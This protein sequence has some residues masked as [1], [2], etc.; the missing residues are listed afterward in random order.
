MTITLNLTIDDAQA[1]ELI[2]NVALHHGWNEMTDEEVTVKTKEQIRAVLRSW[3]VNVARIR[4]QKAA[5]AAAAAA[6]SAAVS[7]S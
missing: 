5:E 3:V 7:V 4:E 1:S 6:V 2:Q